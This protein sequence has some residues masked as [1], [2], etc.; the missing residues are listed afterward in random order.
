[1]SNSTLPM[2]DTLSRYLLNTGVRESSYLK[3]LREETHH[4]EDHMMQIAPEQG[5]F[6]A[7]LVQ[8]LN[9]KNIIEIGVFTGY[10]SL[11]MAEVLPQEGQI[12]ACDI[13]EETTAVAQKYWDKAGVAN[14]IDLRLAPALDTLQSLLNEG[15]HN[16][17]DM[18]FIDADKPAYDAYY[19]KSLEL[20]RPGG[21]ILLDNMLWSGLVADDS[22]QD[23]CTE[24]LRQL[25]QKIHQ[26]DRVNM[27][28]LPLADGISMVRKR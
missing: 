2:T 22:I 19:E 14:H 7:M 23:E 27:V 12:I 21:M 3:Q 26:D 15:K 28:L 6:M 13:N 9:A 11:A 16:S 20:L 18:V 17:I 8:L 1:M 5:Q 10:S 25:N 4:R 24:A